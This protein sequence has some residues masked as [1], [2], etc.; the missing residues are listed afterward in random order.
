M[1]LDFQ[2]S[3]LAEPELPDEYFC[4]PWSQALADRHAMVKF[5]SFQSEIDSQVFRSLS[6]I[7]GC[8]RLVEDITT[9]KAFLPETTWLVSY[10]PSTGGEYQDCATIQ[11]VKQTS[12]MGAIQNVGV[13]PEHRG[14]GIGRALVLQSL[15]GF[16][17]AGMRRVYLEVTAQNKAAVN[18]YRSIGFRL[19]RTMYKAADFD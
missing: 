5:A 17:D 3:V 15:Q 8:R 13:I 10:C 14:M 19:T 9:Q 1:E 11:G 12:V 16:R 18:L 4:L 6:E 7:T 2:E